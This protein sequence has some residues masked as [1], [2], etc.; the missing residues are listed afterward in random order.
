VLLGGVSGALGVFALRYIAA[1]AAAAAAAAAV[2]SEL[3]LLRP[4]EHVVGPLRAAA[5]LAVDEAAAARREGA[6]ASPAGVHPRLL[7]VAVVVL[8]GETRG[9][10]LAVRLRR[11]RREYQTGGVCWSSPAPPRTEL[12]PRNRSWT[13]GLRDSLVTSRLRRPLNPEK[14][15]RLT[16]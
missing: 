15:R 9:G 1:T 14:L 5:P 6:A 12:N 4:L 3:R 13:K 7:A 10:A 16:R 11:D 8:E 2:V